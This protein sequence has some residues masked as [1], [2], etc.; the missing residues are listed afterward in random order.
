V[1]TKHFFFK[2]PAALRPGRKKRSLLRITQELWNRKLPCQFDASDLIL[3]QDGD[4][5]ISPLYVMKASSGGI[6]DEEDLSGLI[7]QSLLSQ[8]ISEVYESISLKKPA[9]QPEICESSEMVYD[10]PALVPVKPS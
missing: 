1:S 7:Y 6:T 8:T 10:S 5:Q 4:L 9:F 2:D 3:R